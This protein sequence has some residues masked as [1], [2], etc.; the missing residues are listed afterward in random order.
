MVVLDKI[1]RARIQRNFGGGLVE[2][3]IKMEEI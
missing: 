3:G 1:N 2:N